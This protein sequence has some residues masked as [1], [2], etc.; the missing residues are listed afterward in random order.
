MM[1]L[2]VVGEE[3]DRPRRQQTI[4]RVR[5]VARRTRL[6]GTQDMINATTGEIVECNIVQME[7][8]DFNFQKLWLGHILEAIDEIGNAKMKVLMYLLNKRDK[9][10]NA[11]IRTAEGIAHDVGVSRQTVGE[12]LK[13]LEQ[14]GIIKR[15]TGA[16]YLNPDVIFKGGKDKR[17]NVLLQYRELD[18]DDE[19]DEPLQEQAH[20]MKQKNTPEYLKKRKARLLAELAELEEL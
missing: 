7:E 9:G 3:E 12:T 13:I 15:V 19:Q 16:V 20:E 4:K 10:N 8:K 14:H 6:V 17:L 18:D 5:S 1:N 2:K 11:V